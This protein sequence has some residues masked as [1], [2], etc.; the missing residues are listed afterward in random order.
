M[1]I[2]T[3]VVSQTF[4]FYKTQ[5]QCV[6]ILVGDIMSV[7]RTEHYHVTEMFRGTGVYG[8]HNSHF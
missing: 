6:K 3:C 2:T 7:D 4:K 1:F 8:E 5:T